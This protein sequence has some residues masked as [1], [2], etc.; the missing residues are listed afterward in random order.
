V[1]LNG[2]QDETEA[3]IVSGAGQVGA[4][5][6]A[7]NMAGRGTDIPLSAAAKQAGGLHVIATDYHESERV[8]RQLMGR[9]ARQGDPGSYQM[10]ASAD[11]ELF[12]KFAPELVKAI[13]QSADKDDLARKDFSADVARLQLRL[14]RESFERRLRLLAQDHWTETML[15][16]FLSES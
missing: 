2:I 8:D 9:C 11:D 1:V 16:T 15:D 3:A 7:T 13:R 4:V 6:I 12:I 5:T 10:M 14:L